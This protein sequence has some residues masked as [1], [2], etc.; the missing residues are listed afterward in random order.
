MTDDD[1]ELVVVLGGDGTMLRGFHE[2]LGR[3]VPVIGVNFGRFGF[4]ASMQPAELETGY[5]VNVPLFIN[6]GDILKI[7]TRTG[8]YLT[9]VG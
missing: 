2:T 8:Q 3:G 5:Q 6:E 1:P 9:R 7:D 4:L